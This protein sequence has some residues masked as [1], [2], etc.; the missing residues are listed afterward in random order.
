MQAEREGV[1]YQGIQLARGK[2][3]RVY[4]KN[5]VIAAYTLTILKENNL[6]SAVYY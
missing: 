3:N 2:K 1:S 5:C 6:E 4:R